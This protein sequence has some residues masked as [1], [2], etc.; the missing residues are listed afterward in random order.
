[1]A[2]LG[3]L[4]PVAV[5]INA[6]LAVLVRSQSEPFWL[7]ALSALCFVLMLV[8]FVVWTQPANQA[9]QNWTTVP[10][11]WETLRRQWEYSHAAN[12]VVLI[13]AFCL[14]TFSALSWRPAT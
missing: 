1:M 5:I 4:W 10:E 3:L 12:T 6:L 14:T 13:I 8:I 11:N 2:F 9:T 7:A